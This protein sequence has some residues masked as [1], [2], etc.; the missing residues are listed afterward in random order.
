MPIIYWMIDVLDIHIAIALLESS[1]LPSTLAIIRR[2]SLRSIVNDIPLR[3]SG[4]SRASDGS[5]LLSEL[6][7]NDSY[8]ST[9]IATSI[10]HIGASGMQAPRGSKS[11]YDLITFVN[12][13]F[14]LRCRCQSNGPTYYA[15]APAQL[16]R[17]DPISSQWEKIRDGTTNANGLVAFLGL[18]ES[19]PGIHDYT[20]SCRGDYG[21]TF[22]NSRNIPRYLRPW[23]GRI[24]HR[25]APVISMAMD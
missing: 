14:F 4:S 15:N 13:P 23:L 24:Q 9:G 11:Q 10:P 6:G 12:R 3:G 5:A 25:N 19:K 8:K 1:T 16:H 7:R 20:V 2:I 17:W 18:K 22:R 21:T